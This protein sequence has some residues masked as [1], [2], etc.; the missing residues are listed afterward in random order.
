MPPVRV[1]PFT[2]E[3]RA[4][5][6]SHAKARHED[7]FAVGRKDTRSQKTKERAMQ[8]DLTGA[9]GDLAY[10]IWRGVEWV[11][12]LRTFKGGEPDFPPDIEVKTS[13]HRTLNLYDDDFAKNPDRPHYG[14]W[15]DRS[16]QP[17]T[18]WVL[19]WARPSEHAEQKRDWYGRVKGVRLEPEELHPPEELPV[20]LDYPRSAWDTEEE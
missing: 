4:R 7:G 17:H 5:I 13:S 3:E 6:L 8:A 16:T 12:K 20:E 10:A 2:I 1:R 9:A 14:V 19:G 11:P 18:Y 15:Q